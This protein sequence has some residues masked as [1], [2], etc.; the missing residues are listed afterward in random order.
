MAGTLT[1]NTATLN[2]IAGN[3][4]KTYGTTITGGPGSTAF[5]VQG[6]K[7]SESIGSVTIAYG[8][9]AASNDPVGTYTGSVTASA[10]TGGTFNANNYT[11]TYSTGNIIV[12]AAPLT[13][14]ADDK[15]KIYGEPNPVLT[16]S[17]SGFV[18]TDNADS[19]TSKP[20]AST[21][22]LTFSPVGQYPI[23]VCCAMSPNYDII[24]LAGTLTINQDPSVVVPNTFTPNGDGINDTWNIKFLDSYPNCTVKIYNRYGENVYSSVGYGIAWNGTYRGI[25]LPQGTYYYIINLQSGLKVLSGS[26]TI[27]R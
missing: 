21:T 18:N 2:I 6:L 10:A 7:N 19:L 1:I 27:I 15:S 8:A 14:T 9:G 23:T 25:Q 3:Q 4:D 5:T 22:A 11:I 12:E 26:V 20:V 24:Y 17:Y 13:I 16:V